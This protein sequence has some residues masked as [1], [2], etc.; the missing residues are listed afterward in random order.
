MIRMLEDWGFAHHGTKG[1]DRWCMS[2]ISVRAS[3]PL[4]DAYFPVRRCQGPEMRG[5]DLPSVPH[6]NCCPTRS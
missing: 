2:A 4:T 3:T 1:D 6:G 5:A